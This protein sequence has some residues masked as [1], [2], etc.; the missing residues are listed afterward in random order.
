MAAPRKVFISSPNPFILPDTTEVVCENSGEVS[1]GGFFKI[2]ESNYECSSGNHTL[3][4]PKIDVFPASSSGRFEIH[5]ITIY[6]LKIVNNPDP[7]ALPRAGQNVTDDKSLRVRTP[8]DDAEGRGY[9][10]DVIHEMEKYENQGVNLQW[11]APG[12]TAYH[13]QQHNEQ[14]REGIS[15]N[16]KDLIRKIENEIENYLTDPDNVGITDARNAARNAVK[17]V[18]ATVASVTGV[19]SE[20]EAYKKTF[21]AL[22]KPEID[23]IQKY[24]RENSWT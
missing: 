1:G 4:E 14:L 11:Y 15:K 10:R 16:L 19:D 18:I 22:W 8:R 5:S 6:T 23:K 3:A 21:A 17:S 13:E 9:W 12:S 24:A 2:H 20:P 7:R